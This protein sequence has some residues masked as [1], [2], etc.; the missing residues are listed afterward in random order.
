M[1][2]TARRR[3]PACR[4]VTS[5]G[6]MQ[7]GGEA[8]G[9]EEAAAGDV[10]KEEVLGGGRTEGQEG[11]EEAA[12]ALGGGKEGGASCCGSSH[13]GATHA[14]HPSHCP[15]GRAAA[16]SSCNVN[17]SPP[18]LPSLCR[19]RQ[20]LVCCDDAVVAQPSDPAAPPPSEGLISSLAMVR[21][22]PTLCAASAMTQPL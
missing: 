22:N 14:C 8:G 10:R 3:G 21:A 1:A 2:A 5:T 15:W 17:K 7:S 9:G 12:A 13:P 20:P 19:C 16:E 18:P 11:V 6:W 4:R